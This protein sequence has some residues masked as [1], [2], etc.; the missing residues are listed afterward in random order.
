MSEPFVAEIRL[1]AGN[2]A[3][4]GWAF[5]NGQLLSIAQNQALFSL[6]GTTYGGD[7]RVT[8]A[9]PDL[10]GRAP[11]HWGNGQGLTPRSLG[12]VSGTENVTLLQAQMPAHT[13][14][15]TAATSRADDDDPS[16]NLLAQTRND[17]YTAPGGA[18]T[19]LAPT[20]VAPSGGNQPFPVMQPYV[21]VSFIIAL[22]GIF[23]ARG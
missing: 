10:Q 19:A 22:Q 12:E 18:T 16:G 5:C 14:T 8:F 3:P 20:A 15:M 17:T 23:P 7:G 6:V 4:R 21:A 13:H 11:M 1:F 9:L 2:F